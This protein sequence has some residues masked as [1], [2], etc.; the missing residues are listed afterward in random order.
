MGVSA[1]LLGIIIAGVPVF[2]LSTGS[3]NLLITFR[4]SCVLSHPDSLSKSWLRALK[5][6]QV[7]LPYCHSPEKQRL[8]GIFNGV[9]S[10]FTALLVL[11]RR[12]T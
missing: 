9:A 10:L 6:L 11:S 1:Q 3:Q 2:S 12:I 8:Q 5:Q 4:M 7:S